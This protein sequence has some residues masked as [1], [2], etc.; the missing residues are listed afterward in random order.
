MNLIQTVTRMTDERE[1]VVTAAP[2]PGKRLRE[3]REKRGL[4]LAQVASELHMD[5]R[6]LR[7]LEE[8]DYSALGAPIF[9]KG[10]LRNYAR[11]LGLDP[12]EIVA[13]YEAAQKPADPDL[14]A[15]RSDGPRMEHHHSSAWVGWLG[16]LF[17]LLLG[18][19]LAGWWYYQQEGGRDFAI[20]PATERQ[21]SP[22]L[23]ESPAVTEREIVPE[24]EE[25]AR[26]ATPPPGD[27]V[28]E[29]EM[30]AARQQTN[31][32]TGEQV[33]TR[34]SQ[35]T[36]TE[37]TPRS[38]RQQ[39]VD[40]GAAAPAQPREQRATPAGRGLVL[41]FDEES[42]VEVYDSEGRP[43]L[44]DLVRP[45]T[46]RQINATGQ[47]RLFLGNASGV[48]VFVNGERFAHERFQRA[49]NTARFTVNVPA[50]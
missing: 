24:L 20:G 23:T 4:S 46:R 40:T 5:Q 26:T 14:V 27:V 42:W 28:D 30:P 18:V 49:D 11:L 29:T 10:H 8:D 21:V 2:M 19:L 3:Q 45:G 7:S 47:L 9:V 44:Y 6:M 41:E 17:L 37:R 32:R 35:D 38:E 33:T 48:D 43:V 36:G 12:I 1:E 15:Q 50:E 16:W 13:E 22:P 39:P 25:E 34:P 31:E